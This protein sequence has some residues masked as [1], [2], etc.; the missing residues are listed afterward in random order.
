MTKQ[1]KTFEKELA[2]LINRHSKE[3]ESDTPDFI[4]AIYLQACLTAFNMTMHMRNDWYTGAA[5]DQAESHRP[6]PCPFCGGAA[7]LYQD[8]GHFYAACTSC[9]ASGIS[10]SNNTQATE[11]WNK[12]S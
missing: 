10:G 2:D 1:D 6:K 3:G 9:G 8:G 7:A 5:L 4:L 12:R 11:R